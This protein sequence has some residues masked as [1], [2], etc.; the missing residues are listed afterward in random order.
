MTRFKIKRGLVILLL[1]LLY[2][3]NVNAA[4]GGLVVNRVDNDDIVTYI[5]SLESGCGVQAANYTLSYK[6]DALEYLD[7]QEGSAA[8]ADNAMFVTNLNL[9][10]K[11]LKLGYISTD[12][13]QEGGVLLT[14]RFKNTDAGTEKHVLGLAVDEMK[15][16]NGNDLSPNISGDTS[17]GLLPAGVTINDAG[18]AP[19]E[20]RIAVTENSEPDKSSEAA[21]DQ[22][23]QPR[24]QALNGDMDH[25]KTDMTLSLQSIMILCVILAVLALA[26][27][28]VL[29]VKKKRDEGS[30][31]C[32]Q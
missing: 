6:E 19:Q 31:D 13:N 23:D 25:Q 9:D 5:V 29:V 15:D 4:E 24:S 27:I 14:I 1:L 17:V 22:N 3:T 2:T 26:L 28:L 32:D 12:P 30:E 21:E 10:N 20:I 8:S 11:W 18:A 7:Q 16:G